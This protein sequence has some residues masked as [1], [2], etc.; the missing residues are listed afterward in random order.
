MTLVIQNASAPFA[1][2]LRELAKIDGATVTTQHKRKTIV[3]LAMEQVAN[4]E[5]EQY[6]T[7]DDFKRAM[8]A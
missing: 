7:L 5:T 3:Q 6:A 1:K 8:E 2:A 4:G